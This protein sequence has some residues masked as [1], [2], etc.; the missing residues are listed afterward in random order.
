[1]VYQHI[2]TNNLKCKAKKFVTHIIQDWNQL[3]SE[4]VVWNRLGKDIIATKEL[5]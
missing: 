2:I 5:A 3:I 4:L 1:M